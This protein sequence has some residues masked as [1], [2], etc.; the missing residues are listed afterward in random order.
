M[1]RRLEIVERDQVDRTEIRTEDGE[2]VDLSEVGAPWLRLG[3]MRV[4]AARREDDGSIAKSAGLALHL[5]EVAAVVGDEVVARVLAERH[6]DS[7][8]GTLQRQDDRERRVVADVLR[9]LHALR[10][11]AVSDRPCPK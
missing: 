7:I 4:A 8:S 11:P 10:V 3:V 6:R 1:A 9:M 2:V 5:A